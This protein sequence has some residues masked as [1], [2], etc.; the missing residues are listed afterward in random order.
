VYFVINRLSLNLP[1]L[2]LTPFTCFYSVDKFTYVDY[3]GC[4]NSANQHDFSE[5]LEWK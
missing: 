1:A 2:A 4:D 5:A 3:D